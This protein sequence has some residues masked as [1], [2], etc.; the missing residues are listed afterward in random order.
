MSIAAIG[1]AINV[2]VA[3]MLSRAAGNLNARGALLHV[4]GDLLGSVVALVAGAVIWATGWMPIDPMLSLVVA[5]LILRSTWQL[6]RESAGVLMEGVPDHLSYDAIGRALAALPGVTGVHDLHVWGMS[7]ER[8][9][10]LGPRYA[11]R[12]RHVAEGAGPGAANAGEGFRHRPRHAAIDVAGGAC[13][14][15]RDPAR[16]RH[17]PRGCRGPRLH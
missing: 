14:A 8:V 16:A 13:P 4:M 5:F 9:A 15:A 3:W 17:R 12:R 11:D 7:A 10:L 1:L 6:L 2:L